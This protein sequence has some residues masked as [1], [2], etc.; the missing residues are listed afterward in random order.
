M[1]P[2]LPVLLDVSFRIFSEIITAD[3][4]A[5]LGRESALRSPVITPTSSWAASWTVLGL[6]NVSAPWR[7][8]ARCPTA[9]DANRQC[10]HCKRRNI[11]ILCCS[12][13]LDQII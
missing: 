12:E 5:W 9:S 11:V 3:L 8:G 10:V 7:S 4:A 13:W 1:A 6:Q 2:M